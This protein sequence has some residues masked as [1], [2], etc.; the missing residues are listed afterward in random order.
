MEK[1]ITFETLKK[2]FESKYQKS[3]DQIKLIEEEILLFRIMLYGEEEYAD[4]NQ[5]YIIDLSPRSLGL[6][7]SIY[8]IERISNAFSYFIIE[9]NDPAEAEKWF[10]S[11]FSTSKISSEE[12]LI[13]STFYANLAVESYRFLEYLEG[14]KSTPVEK[15]DPIL[16][17][18]QLLLIFNYFKEYFEETQDNWIIR[19]NYPS[20]KQIVPIKLSSARRM[21][22]D[23]LII[24]GILACI[25]K[26]RE[27]VFDYADFVKARFGIRGY[28]TSKSR[29]KEKKDFIKAFNTCHDILK[30][31]NS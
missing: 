15:I 28:E 27:K 14:L 13:K 5:R 25:Q 4:H 20:S 23:R 7:L 29:Y 22:E 24:F 11:N 19:F 2:R 3:R 31:A 18:G 12:L 10:K 16:P 6:T 26:R 9:G 1:S 17:I 30:N 21:G 8:D